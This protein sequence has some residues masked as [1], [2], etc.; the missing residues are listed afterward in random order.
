MKEKFVTFPQDHQLPSKDELRGKVYCKYHNSWNHSIKYCWGFRNVIQDKVKKEVTLN[1][2]GEK[3]ITVKFLGEKE[4][5]MNFFR[6]NEVMVKPLGKKEAMV[7][8]EDPLPPEGSINIDATNSWA[9][10]NAK[11]PMKFS[12]SAKVRKHKK[13]SQKLTRTQ[14][15]RMQR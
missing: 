14:K 7:I 3:E 12:P 11:K 1:F 10:Q 15:R 6:E 5:T 13:F 9:M 4:V 2:L 8:D